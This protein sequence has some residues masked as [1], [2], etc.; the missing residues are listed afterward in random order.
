MM[1]GTYRHSVDA[2][3]RLFVPAKLKDAL[4]EAFYVTIS[5]DPCLTIYTSEKLQKLLDRVDEMPMMQA[6]RL[7][8]LFANVVRCEPD[9]QGRFLLP[10]ELRQRAGISQDVTIIGQGSYAEIWDTK[11]YEA[12]DAE[13]TMPENLAAAMEEARL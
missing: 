8:G 4:G 9:K 13:C 7:R 1:L 2:K 11:T 5:V 6:R 12:V 10:A 3:G